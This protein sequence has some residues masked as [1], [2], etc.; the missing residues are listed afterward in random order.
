MRTCRANS[1]ST[2]LCCSTLPVL[3]SEPVLTCRPRPLDSH[4]GNFDASEEKEDAWIR[5][6]RGTPEVTGAK[7]RSDVVNFLVSLM[8]AEEV[9]K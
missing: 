7:Q 2:Q 4:L 9:P 3:K 6:D 8:L 1:D 5:A